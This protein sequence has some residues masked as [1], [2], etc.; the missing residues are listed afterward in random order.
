LTGVFCRQAAEIRYNAN[1]SLKEFM[2]QKLLFGFHAVQARLRVAPRSVQE[3]YVENER[4]DK[5]MQNFIGLLAQSRIEPRLVAR[6]RLDG[7]VGHTRH[8]GIAALVDDLPLAHSLDDV[9]ENACP[10][11][12]FLLVLDGVTDPHNLGACLRVADAAGVH[13]VIA[14]R[15]TRRSASTPPWLK[16]PRARPSMCR[17]SW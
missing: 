11:P 6:T 15:R 4:A 7:L 3:V 5:R 13:A 1:L 9:L 8:Q 17:T 2:A 16:S 10:V 14:H 12:P